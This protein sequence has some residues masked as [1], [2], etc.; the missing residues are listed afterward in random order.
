MK[1]INNRILFLL[2]VCMVSGVQAQ[3]WQQM[4]SSK[5][6]AIEHFNEDKFGLFIHWGIYSV[7]GGMYKGQKM[8]DI[9]S[10]EPNDA[11]WIQARARIPRAEYQQLMKQ[12]DPVKFNADEYVALIKEAGMKYVVITSKHHD[13]FALWDS[14]VSDFDMGSTP[15]KRNLVKELYDACQ[16][17]GVDFGVYYSHNIDWNDAHDCNIKTYCDVTGEVW[18]EPA[19][20]Q[21]KKRRPMGANLWDPSPNTFDEYLVNKAYPQVKELLEM[22]PNMKFMWYDFAHFLSKDQSFKFYQLVYQLNPNIIVTD[23]VG[24]DLGDFN[25][26]GDNKIPNPEDMGGKHWET[27]GTFNNSWG[28]KEYDKDFKSP[29]ELIYWITAIASRGGNYMLNIG[30]KGDG[31]IPAES[32]NNLKEIGKW[33][34][35]NGK[36]IYGTKQWKV[37]REGED[38]QKMLGTGHR[39]THGFT[40]NFTTSDFWFTTKGN[41]VYAIA[42]ERGKEALIKSFAGEEIKVVKLLGHSKKLKWKQTAEGLSIVL[43]KNKN[44]QIGYAVEVTIES[45][46]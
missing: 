1:W 37:S 5:K 12:F 33:M 46:L 8:D 9:V 11:C 2:L 39:A 43:P 24:H 15:S 14:K 30:P 25:I 27:V 17:Q 38:A 34:S 35:V 31:S 6:E 26:P 42:L 45:S 40:A 10:P 20:F 3:T 16:R 13:G 41:K 18:P 4:N 36:A 29:Y 21:G 32:V 22:F 23:R 28:Y 44:N 19:D 7:W